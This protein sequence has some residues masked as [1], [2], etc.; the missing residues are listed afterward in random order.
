MRPARRAPLVSPEKFRQESFRRPLGRV[1]M[2]KG[3]F[4]LTHLGHVEA[5]WTARHKGDTLVVAVA[6]DEV[7]RARKGDDRPILNFRE[8]IG[9]LSSLTMVDYLVA[10]DDTSIHAT[11]S[12]V[13]PDVFCA[14]H[15]DSLTP[16]QISALEA[17]GVEFSL[18][19]KPAERSTTDIILSIREVRG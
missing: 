4:D 14:S 8:R 7:T 9:I 11:L 2:S 19:P 6:G 1:V 17:S 12:I 3:V 5:L 13:A 15:F 10:Y 18:I 16:T